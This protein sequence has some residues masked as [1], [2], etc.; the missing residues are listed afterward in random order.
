MLLIEKECSH[1]FIRSLIKVI[2]IV[3]AFNLSISMIMIDGVK[4]EMRN[5]QNSESL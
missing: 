1:L 4:C 5:Y 3:I 2:D